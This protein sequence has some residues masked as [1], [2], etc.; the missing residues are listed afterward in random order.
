MLHNIYST[1][2]FVALMWSGEPRPVYPSLRRNDRR[3]VR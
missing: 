2:L 3:S 1:A